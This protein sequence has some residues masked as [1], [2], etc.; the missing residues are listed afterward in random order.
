MLTAF[1]GICF[2]VVGSSCIR[3]IYHPA[4]RASALAWFFFGTLV[5]PAFGPF[6]G[7]ILITYYPWR[8]IFWLQTA[9]T[10][11]GTLLILVFLPETIEH[12]LADDLE[13]LPRK[14][15]ARQL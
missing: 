9:V 2:F 15:K 14:A 5:G 12:K 6:V 3:D 10:G 8:S 4:L 7:G 11:F 13:G 1:E